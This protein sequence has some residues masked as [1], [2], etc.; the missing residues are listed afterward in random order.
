MVQKKLEAA[1]LPYNSIS[2]FS[3]KHMAI[4]FSERILLKFLATII[5]LY[6]S[7]YVQAQPGTKELKLDEAIRAAVENNKNV[8][9]SQMDEKI[10]LAN[11]KQTE[12]VFLPQ[13]AL[14]YT[15]MVTNNPLNA[16][17]AKLQE[18]K[19]SQNDFNPQLLNHPSGTSDFMTRMDLQQPIFNMDK[20]YQR[21]SAL[22]QS[23]LYQF[24]TQRTKEFIT[25][26]VQ[27]AYMQLQLAYEAKKVLDDGLQTV[28]AIY[29]FTNDRYSQ[30]LLQK[31]DVLNVEVEVKSAES[32]IADA[33]SNIKNASDY[34]SLLMNVPAGTVYQTEANNLSFSNAVSTDSL[35][36]DRADFKAM[37]VAIKSYDLMIK[38]SKMSYLPRLNAFA[39]YQL[40]DS[41]VLGFGANAYLAGLQLTWDI[42]KGNQTKNKISTQV[43]ERNKMEEEL[44]KQKDESNLELQKTVR[45]LDDAKFKIKQQK[46][47]V[48]LADEALRIL[49]N[50]YQQG[51]VNTTDVL[52]AETQLSK[53]KLMYQQ[54]VY[55]AN[56]T[57]AYLQFLT[58]K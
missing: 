26:Q 17:G 5:L 31:S 57:A 33:A 23:E 28:N 46:S 36:E 3:K 34:L 4:K 41:K 15:G 44:A 37:E 43:L 8:S 58:I 51:L 40:N 53:Q 16:F 1:V 42:F 38:S 21:K 56:V 9:L 47:A 24:K 13:V 48:D 45:Q 19:I 54:A 39:S 30:G 6:L 22:K 29:K 32:N 7:S 12:A 20:L 49:Q 25:Y 18:R 27:Q 14:S 2:I 55:A 10:A 50:R 35:P 52:T 11:Y